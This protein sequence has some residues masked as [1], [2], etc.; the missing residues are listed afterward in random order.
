MR[1]KLASSVLLLYGLTWTWAAE[2]A[3][4]GDT[5]FVFSAPPRGERAKEQGI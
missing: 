4:A 1:L 5:E 2:P 3:A